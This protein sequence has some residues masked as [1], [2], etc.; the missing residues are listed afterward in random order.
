MDTGLRNVYVGVAHC[1]LEGSEG[2]LKIHERLL[3]HRSEM[4]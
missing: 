2:G 1:I 3:T 4:T